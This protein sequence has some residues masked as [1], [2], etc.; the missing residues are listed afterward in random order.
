L[1]RDDRFGGRPFAEVSALVSAQAYDERF[2][3]TW[4]AW[5]SEL[6]SKARVRTFSD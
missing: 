2:E 4:A 5:V 3:R 1:H 6:V